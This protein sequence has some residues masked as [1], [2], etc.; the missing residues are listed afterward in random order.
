M[1]RQALLAL[2][3][4]STPYFSFPQRLAGFPLTFSHNERSSS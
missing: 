3:L 1:T 4:N 2:I